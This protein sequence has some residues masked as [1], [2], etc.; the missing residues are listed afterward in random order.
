[1]ES[2]RQAMRARR[3]A[4]AADLQV[5]REDPVLQ[6]PAATAQKNAIQPRRSEADTKA[7]SANDNAQSK[8]QEDIAQPKEPSTDALPTKKIDDRAERLKRMRERRNRTI[9]RID[10]SQSQ[11]TATPKSVGAQ[12]NV[13]RI[14]DEKDTKQMDQQPEEQKHSTESMHSPGEEN[15]QTGERLDAKGGEGEEKPNDPEHSTKPALDRENPTQDAAEQ[16]SEVGAEK[17][18]TE[19]AT[20]THDAPVTDSNAPDQLPISSSGDNN[21]V[22]AN[23]AALVQEPDFVA[24]NPTPLVADNAEVMRSSRLSVESPEVRTVESPEVKTVEPPEVKTVDSP[25]VRTVE[26]PEVKTVDSLEVRTV[27]SPEVKTVESPEVRTVDPDTTSTQILH[28]VHI[29]ETRPT[30]VVPTTDALPNTSEYSSTQ[31]NGQVRMGGGKG[32]TGRSLRSMQE[33]QRSSPPSGVK[34]R[35]ARPVPNKETEAQPGAIVSS[36]D[37]RHGAPATQVPPR[38]GGEKTSLSVDRHVNLDK[39]PPTFR[40]T[41]PTPKSMV[42]PKERPKQFSN[43]NLL[44]HSGSPKRAFR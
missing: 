35:F 43:C 22:S 32:K 25:E 2:R 30:V 27:E 42:S 14:K 37:A 10:Q 12:D 34:E 36:P 18:N 6:S 17:S 21:Q 20:K 33:K 44:S 11:G 8:T 15:T 13:E 9:M 24:M 3:V 29:D 16:L 1:M 26:S 28:E 7:Q 40:P 5:V 41:S 23:Q 39:H 31:Q 19:G 4:Q 38:T